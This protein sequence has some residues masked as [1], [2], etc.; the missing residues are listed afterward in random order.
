MTSS[1][2]F[3]T[4]TTL[5]FA[6][7]SKYKHHIQWTYCKG[8]STYNAKPDLTWFQVTY[9]TALTKKYRTPMEV[10]PIRTYRALFIIAP[11]RP[12]PMFELVVEAFF[13]GSPVTL[14]MLGVFLSAGDL[15][16][17]VLLLVS[18]AKETAHRVKTRGSSLKCVMVACVRDF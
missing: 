9:R 2:K 11:S 4:M 16:A 12:K 7:L 3:L 5:H 10:I 14:L 13:W 17:V 8:S 6:S 1:S 18:S 15:V